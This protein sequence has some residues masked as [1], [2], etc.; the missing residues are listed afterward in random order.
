MAY[1]EG[2]R[3]RVVLE[4]RRNAV[5][6]GTPLIDT[7]DIQ[8]I[9]TRR[10]VVAKL[11]TPHRV[12]STSHVNGGIQEE[13]GH[14]VNHQSCEAAGHND[15]FEFIMGMGQTAYHHHVCEELGIDALRSATMGTAANMQYAAVAEASYEEFKVHA[16]VTAGVT[17]NAGR[18]GDP[19]HYLERDG[20]YEKL[21]QSGTI[22]TL[23]FFNAA[24]ST[25]AL[26]RAVVTMTEAKSAVLQELAVRSRCGEGIATGT[27]T[28]Q[29][30]IA[31]PLASAGKP[32]TWTGKHSKI[33]ELLGTA[34]KD[35]TREALRWQNGMEP[36][37]TRNVFHAL[38]AFGFKEEFFKERMKEELNPEQLEL[39]TKNYKSVVFEPNLAAAAYALAAVKDRANY[40]V[41]PP[42]AASDAVLN[43]CSLLAAAL[44]AK[45]ER[46]ADMRRQLIPLSGKEFPELVL[47]SILL[48]WREKWND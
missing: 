25:S 22:N 28:D 19:A 1:L 20:Q 10:Y 6:D 15:R 3:R 42:N 24:L 40:G 38:E 35:A 13:L 32:L 5:K 37:Y 17:G 16:I 21:P 31:A 39:V 43:Q 14:L 2:R 47:Q 26:T 36:S 33:G 7:D 23:V 44:S 45:P 18:A 29:F 11:K 48:G 46:Y 41:L 8:V 4:A 30:C 27:G 12:I 34:V 9:R